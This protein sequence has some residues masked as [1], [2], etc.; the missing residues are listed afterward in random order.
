[1]PAT[2][3]LLRLIRLLRLGLHLLQG[4]AMAALVFPFVSSARRDGIVRGW[5][6]KVL[7]ILGVRLRVHGA[8]PAPDAPG[9]V[10]VSNHISW[11]DVWLIDSQRA[12]R[13]VAKSEV[14]N[15]PVIGWLAARTGTLFIQ[16]ARRH[17]TA[18]L[19]RQIDRALREGACVAMF[20]EGT[21]TDGR[22]LK[23][24]FTSLLQPAADAGAPLVPVAIR[25]LRED[26]EIDLTPA[27][28]DRM[29]LAESLRRVLAAREILVELSFLPPID[30]RGKSRRD[31]AHAA[32]AA[33]AAAL[34]LPS[35]GTT[36]ETAPDLPDA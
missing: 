3:P 28:I 12:C 33:I 26:G 34:R 31:I 22:Q 5:S 27:Y 19:N 16:R 25:Y 6:R 29:S 24:F 1:M 13:F 2:P 15:W 36:P 30:T 14:R 18:A 23:R 7:A 20:P 9:V 4:L 32:E 35:P 17:H 11:L 8:A 21:T 10:F